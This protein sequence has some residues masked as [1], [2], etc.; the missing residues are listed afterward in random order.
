MNGYVNYFFTLT[1]TTGSLPLLPPTLHLLP[2][3][4]KGYPDLG[5]RGLV[6]RLVEGLGLPGFLLVDADVHVLE[7]AATYKYGP[8]VRLIHLFI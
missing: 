2:L 7:I 6:R 8:K 1:W 5:T 3:Q 4:G